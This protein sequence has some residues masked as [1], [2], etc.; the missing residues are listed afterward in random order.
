[1][2]LDTKYYVQPFKKYGLLKIMLA[3]ILLVVLP[4]C[5]KQT[6]AEVNKMDIITIGTWRLTGLKAYY[7]TGE[8]DVYSTYTSC[9]KDD[10]IKFNKDGTAEI[11]EGPSKCDSTDP[12][13]QFI[14][15]KFLDNSGKRIEINGVEYIIDM[16]DDNNFRIHTTRR[17]PYD[18]QFVKTYGR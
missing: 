3:G 17:D 12:Q 16:L 10:Y 4:C 8:T 7:I 11:N 1:M 13:S 18:S 6:T 9:R 5:K 2:I 15:W 14:Q